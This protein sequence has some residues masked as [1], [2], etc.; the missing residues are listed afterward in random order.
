M[1]LAYRKGPGNLASK[2][3]LTDLSGQGN[4]AQHTLFRAKLHSP[5]ENKAE[6]PF[7]F[8]LPCYYQEKA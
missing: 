1:E 5:P 8:P 6:Y 3:S 7:N 4:P 2:Q